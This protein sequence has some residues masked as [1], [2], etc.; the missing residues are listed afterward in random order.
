MGSAPATFEPLSGEPGDAEVAALVFDTLFRVDAGKPRPHLLVSFDNS[1]THARLVL[2]TD[3]K[4]HDGTPL[5]AA[6]VAASLN[7][8][9]KFPA[10]WMLAPITAARAV[11]DDVVELTLSRPAPDLPWLLATPAAAVLPGGTPRP[12]PVGSGPF[13]V[14]KTERGGVTLRAWEGY[15]GGRPY[16][17]H[18]QLRSFASRTEEAG[19]YEIGALQASRHGTSAF[20]S[21]APRHAASSATVRQG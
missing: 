1:D 16:L 11:G 4:F 14:D 12:R 10:G 8:A 19:A 7:H 2:R 20:E 3:I 18:L 6:D 21:G 9:L 17:D 5:R 13:A 15:F